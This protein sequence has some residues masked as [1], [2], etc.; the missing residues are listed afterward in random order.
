MASRLARRLKYPIRRIWHFLY[1][2]TGLNGLD[3]SVIPFLPVGPG[4]FIEAGANDGIKQSNTYYL[5]KRRGW[6]GLLVEPIP[7]LAAKCKKNRRNSIVES[8]VLVPPH[9][10]GTSV[11]VLDLD[12]MT[13]VTGSEGSL[14]NQKE[15]AD[16]AERVQGITGRKVRVQ[17]ITLSEL[18]DKVGNPEV[19]FFSL[20]VEGF[21][22]EVLRGLDLSRHRPILILIET[23]EIV[24]IQELLGDLYELVNTFTHHDYLF[25]LKSHLLAAKANADFPT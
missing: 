21:E 22:I 20:D 12:L 9:R 24:L 8:F 10:S 13:M 23:K 15:H 7:S 14:L 4:F 16:N 11:E 6:K 25:H 5:E 18:I 3:K 17:G 2:Y 1:P 19:T